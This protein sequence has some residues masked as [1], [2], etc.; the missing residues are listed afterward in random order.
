MSED[1]RP[2]LMR[3]CRSTTSGSSPSLDCHTDCSAATIRYRRFVQWSLPMC[4]Q[5][6]TL[7]FWQVTCNRLAT[8]EVRVPVAISIFVK[9]LLFHHFSVLDRSARPSISSDT[10]SCLFSSE[11]LDALVEERAGRRVP[12]RMQKVVRLCCSRRFR[13]Q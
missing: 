4:I 13:M 5:V 9:L 12:T 6:A 10:T 7:F 11:Y 8:V 1:V 2:V 3:P